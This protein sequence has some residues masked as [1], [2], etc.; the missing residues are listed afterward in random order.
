MSERARNWI[1]GLVATAVAVAL[2]VFITL[3]VVRARSGRP[4]AAQ[5]DLAEV[6]RVPHV[7]FRD[8][9]LTSFGRLAGEPIAA[10][11]GSR[12]DATVQCMRAHFAR[13][14]VGARVGLC[15][16]ADPA[17]DEHGSVATLRALDTSWSP[18]WSRTVA[19]I[20]SRL[21]VSPHGKVGAATVFVTGHGYDDQTMS[22]QT[23]LIEMSTGDVLADLEDF[24]I[25]NGEEKL[26]EGVNLWGVTF[27]QD[28]DHFFV[29]VSRG[30]TTWLAKGSVS[31][32]LLTTLRQNVECP[33]L[34]PDE[35]TI[36]FKKRGAN[37]TETHL[38][39]LETATL[40]E[41]AI[42]GETRVVDDQAEWLDA[43]TVLYK[44][45]TDLYAADI[46]GATPPRVFIEQASSPAIV[47]R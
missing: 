20:P 9:E 11:G 17:P 16:E 25:R 14:P 38:F 3:R 24:E 44:Y 43:H 26:H 5:P 45:G 40:A 37:R 12:T 18:T 29:S 32:H 46:T 15:F 36:V 27:A 35:K 34:S 7:L 22:T 6:E 1:F 31:S 33:S 13:S 8:L 2:G 47:D 19:G 39:T 4:G 42:E 21:R 23:L 30:E 10:V 41:R 28:D